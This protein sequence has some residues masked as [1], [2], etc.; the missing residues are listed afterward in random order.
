M[1]SKTPIKLCQFD[2]LEPEADNEALPWALTQT[3]GSDARLSALKMAATGLVQTK[4][5]ELWLHSAMKRLMAACR[6]AVPVR[7]PRYWWRVRVKKK[8]ST[9]LSHDTEVAVKWKVCR[10]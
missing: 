5:R 3:D 7:V 1:V 4:D 9:A 8:P 10:G 2:A 6:L